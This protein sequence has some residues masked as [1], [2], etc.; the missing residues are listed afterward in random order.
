MFLA[1]LA[2]GIVPDIL[3]IPRVMQA[4]RTGKGIPYG[5]YPAETFDSIERSTRPDYLHQIV[6]QWLPAVPGIVEKLR[7]GGRAADL[8]SGA[9]LASIAI[10]KAFPRAS[11]VGFEPYA[12]SVARATQN[13]KSAGV[14][15]RATF[16]SF[17]GV[18]V[19][20]GPYDLVTI[21]Y[22]LHHAGDPVNLMR[23]TRKVLAPGGAFLIVEYRKSAQLEDD[24]DSERRAL[25]PVGLLECMPTAL[26]EGG[27]GYGT[28]IVEPE[29]R[30]LAAEAGFG[31]VAHILVDDP[32]RSF[33]VLRA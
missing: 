22:S 2:E 23:S 9:G 21:N 20:G 27:P 13:A 26:A 18:H 33:F 8:G 30:R 25:Y 14:S 24:I 1:G 5:D 3:M 4:F 10:A 17:D 7:A 6:Q 12:P 11:T 15:D 29:I 28:G 19:P 16:E 32:L 31:Q